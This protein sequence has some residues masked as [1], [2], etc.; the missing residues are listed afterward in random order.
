MTGSTFV[1]RL[2]GGTSPIFI[3]V[4][5]QSRNIGGRASSC[6][7]ANIVVNHG[8]QFIRSEGNHPV[9]TSWLKQGIIKPL[10]HKHNITSVDGGSF[11]GF[12]LSKSQFYTPTNGTMNSIV[13]TEIDSW[14]SKV[15]NL[16]KSSKVLSVSQRDSCD[17]NNSSNFEVQFQERAADGSI[18]LSSNSYDVVVFTDVGAILN[19]MDGNTLPSKFVE[20]VRRV[21][22]DNNGRLPLFSTIVKFTESLPTDAE[23]IV[24][25]D[26][27]AGVGVHYARKINADTWVLISSTQF[28]KAEI[29]ARPMYDSNN[30]IIPQNKNALREF[31]GKAMAYEF[32][33]NLNS[34]SKDHHSK[35]EI[36]SLEC[37]RWG[38]AISQPL[39][40]DRNKKHFIEGENFLYAA[41]D[42]LSGYGG[43]E[44]AVT[45]ATNAADSLMGKI[46]S[47]SYST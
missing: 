39:S 23:V 42:F 28:A 27:K 9:F 20:N 6:G 25:N 33:S 40:N 19:N 11:C 17:N 18:L 31:P 32:L 26:E 13:Q 14:D 45:S 1:S 22:S 36:V 47:Y 8:A 12:P 34:N 38:S 2:L 44:G 29:L 3:D 30:K 10:S 24:F 35:A 15:V 41:S 21:V 5:E 7:F 46:G 43:I 37:Q 4:F 16:R